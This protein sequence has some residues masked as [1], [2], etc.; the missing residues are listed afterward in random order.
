MRVYP[1]DDL[2][3]SL[4]NIFDFDIYKSETIERLGEIL[5]HHGYAFI[6]VL[7]LN[8]VIYMHAQF[9]CE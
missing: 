8:L 7:P 9:G 1:D 6:V 4:R 2:G 3:T 5:E